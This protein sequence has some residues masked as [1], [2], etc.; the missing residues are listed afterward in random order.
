MRLVRQEDNLN[1]ETLI[2][3]P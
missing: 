2:D 3:I 1:K